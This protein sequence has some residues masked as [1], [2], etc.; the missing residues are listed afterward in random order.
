FLYSGKPKIK[1]IDDAL[2]VRFAAKK[3][4][5]Q[6]LNDACCDYI[7]KNLKADRGV[8]VCRPLHAK[9]RARN[10]HHRGFTPG[11]VQCLSHPHL[12]GVQLRP[13]GNC[14]VHRG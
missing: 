5:V 13:R 9:P 8:L 7:A 1:S 4:L 14:P 12:E 6:G 11:V 10:G 3:Y 2:R